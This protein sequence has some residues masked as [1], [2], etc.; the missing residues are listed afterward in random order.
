MAKTQEELNQLKQE[1]KT[2][3][4][5]LKELNDDELELVAGGI[6]DEISASGLTKV[7]L[8]IAYGECYITDVR[9]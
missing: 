9:R 2:L 6:R 3:A 8:L 4:N 1:C 7:G 5:K